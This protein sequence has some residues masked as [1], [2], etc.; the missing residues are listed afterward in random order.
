MLYPSEGKNANFQQKSET[1]IKQ[2]ANYHQQ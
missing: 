1:Q 2:L